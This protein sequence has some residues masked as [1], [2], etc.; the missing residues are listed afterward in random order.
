MG[1]FQMPLFVWSLY[2]TAIIQV[3]ATPVLAIT[4]LLLSAERIIGN[5]FF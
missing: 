5:R 1:F 2:S 3:L 4:L